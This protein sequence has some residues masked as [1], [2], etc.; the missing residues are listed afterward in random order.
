[1]LHNDRPPRTLCAW[2]HNVPHKSKMADGH[3]LQNTINCYISATVWPILMKFCSDILGLQF[4]WAV[5]IFKF[6]KIQYSGWPQ[7]WQE[8]S[9][10]WN[11]W[12]WPQHTWAEKRGAAV[13]LSWKL[14]PRLVQCGLGRGLLP[15]QAASSSIQ[16]FGYNRHG[17]IIGWGM[18]GSTWNTMSH[19]PRTSSVPSGILIHAAVWPQ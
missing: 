16:P 13:P 18:G 14:G 9:S 5:K 11:G 1:M 10:S 15:Y 4:I 6:L 3:H 2:F 8:L 12:P 17:P 7:F 19:R